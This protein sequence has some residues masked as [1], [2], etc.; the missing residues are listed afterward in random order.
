M[1]LQLTIPSCTVSPESFN[2][3]DGSGKAHR[4]KVAFHGGSLDIF[5]DDME[6]FALVPPGDENSWDVTVIIEPAM[7]TNK[8]GYP[9]TRLMVRGVASVAKSPKAYTPSVEPVRR[10]RSTGA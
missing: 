2:K 6:K 5:M 4:W 8:A 7:G 9:E 10:E 3:K 1:L